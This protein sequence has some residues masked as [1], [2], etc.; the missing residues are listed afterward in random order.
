MEPVF[1]SGTS[2]VP[3]DTPVFMRRVMTG[4]EANR[5]IDS[6]PDISESEFSGHSPRAVKEH[7]SASMKSHD[8]SEL[9]GM[10]K[11]IWHKAERAKLSNK[12]LSRIEL[13]YM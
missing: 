8:T 5:L 11:E 7:Y 1:G 2:Y 4:D 9:I 6:I 12:K 3:V 13:Q 10:I